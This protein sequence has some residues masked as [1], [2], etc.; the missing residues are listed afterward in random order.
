[1]H[2]ALVGFAYAFAGGL[3][4]GLFGFDGY[5]MIPILSIWSFAAKGGAR[6]QRLIASAGLGK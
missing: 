6:F 1:V 5:C 3:T 2:A 4:L